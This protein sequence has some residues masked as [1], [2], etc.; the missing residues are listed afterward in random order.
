MAF[1]MIYDERNRQN[2]AK[3]ADN[4]KIATLKWYQY[5]IDNEIQILIYETI[6]SIETQRQNVA[7]GASKTMQ[8]YHLVGQALDFVPV[9]S[10]GS[11]LWNGYK[12]QD[13]QKAYS[14]ARKLGFE[15]GYDWGWDSPHLQY[16]YKGYGT[17]T[18][19][20]VKV[21][22]NESVKKSTID[23]EMKEMDFTSPTL[24]TNLEQRLISPATME[25]IDEV[26]QELLGYKPKLKDGKLADG[27][28]F[29]MAVEIAVKCGKEHKSKK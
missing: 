13:I 14:Y 8:S 3:L 5:C 18:F 2:I 29:A 21:D 12:A 19:G 10:K 1:K 7:K 20:K 16:N 9:D 4:T 22:V 15:L 24:K 23:K 6:R 27:D 28:M 26:A 25:L 17:D 11:A